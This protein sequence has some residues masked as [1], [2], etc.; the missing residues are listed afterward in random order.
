MAQAAATER[1]KE[2]LLEMR[3]RLRDDII[4]IAGRSEIPHIA[5]FTLRSLSLIHI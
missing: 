3:S 4:S 2:R 1:H 5:H